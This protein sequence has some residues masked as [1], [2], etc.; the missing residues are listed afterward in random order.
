MGLRQ[1]GSVIGNYAT[2]SNISASGIWTG[3]E[4]YTLQKKGTWQIPP[5]FSVSASA[6]NVNEG[7]SVTFTLS[8]T[9]VA[10]GVLIPYTLSGANIT[11]LDFGTNSL[12]GNF[13][14]QNGTGTVSI[15]PSLDI[16]TEDNE[17]LQINVVGSTANVTINDT[18][19]NP[20]PQF[21]YVSLLLKGDG[22]NNSQNNTFL[23]SSPNPSTIT[24]N[25]N[26]TQGTFTPYGSNW[27]TF[28]GY[29]AYGYQNLPANTGY[30]VTGTDFT[31]EFWAN[32]S[33]WN[34]MGSSGMVVLGNF[35][36]TNGW[37]VSWNG[38]V[39]GNLSFSTYN[40]GA[41]VA[42]IVSTGITAGTNFQL[43]T[44]NHFTVMQKTNVIYFY[45]NGVMTYST[46]APAAVG[47]GQA[48][49]VGV[50]SQNFSYAGNPYFY[51]SNLRIIKGTGIYSTAGFT[52]PTTPLTPIAGTTLLIGQS[53][54]LVDK[55]TINATIT[56]TESG[57]FPSIQR[58]SPFNTGG[59]YSAGGIDG[60]SAYFDGTG[61]YLSIPA[62]SA[63]TFG[64][65]DHTIEFWYYL[66]S[67]SLASGYSTQWIYSSG[68]TQQATNDYFFQIGTATGSNVGLLLGGGGAWAV[69]IQPS[70]SVNAFVGVWTHI[71]WTR[72][73]NTFRLFFNGVQ[74]GTATY[75]GSIT[76]Q[77]G[78]M[79]ISRD[80][81][82][83]Y[84]GGYYS[85]F[86]INNGTSIYNGNFT[87]PT[88]PLTAIGSTSAASY[89]STANVNITFPQ[90]NTSLLCNFTNAGIIDN[91]MMLNLETQTNAK[92]STTQSKFGGSSMSFDGSSALS[93]PYNSLLNFG[94]GNFTIEFWTYVTATPSA[95]QYF[96][97]TGPAGGGGAHRGFR[98]AAHN[99]S[100]AGI[101]F[102]AGGIASNAETLLGSFPSINAWHHIA[103]V[104]NGTTITGY[105]DGTAL[106]T[107]INASTTAINNIVSGEYSFVGA[108]QDTAPA[109]RLF[110][111]GYID[112]LR[113]TN[114]YARYTTNFTPTT[115]SF[116]N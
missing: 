70:V 96:L 80:G 1:R 41:G 36:S 40:A 15:S 91:A 14:I 98:M 109:G 53:S 79:Y 63:F 60:G 82:S 73:G 78:P 62:N 95:E 114:G 45:L 48:M 92:I 68:A 90:A 33:T 61:D 39:G 26:S 110:Y 20:D 2:A 66:P 3:K 13:V 105:V 71:A 16:S 21:Q 49:Y 72:S 107:T 116:P 85:D 37:Y 5:T 24:R 57:T 10:N 22:T 56:N 104:R 4:A 89:S 55:S 30:D 67:I 74:V 112:D 86:R 75:S 111:N 17:V 7:S 32:F 50:Y 65:N 101:Y 25:G 100:A 44:W 76:A 31:I 35:I 103:I 42:S 12:S 108:L 84:S 28:I 46:A 27:S 8:T 99:G 94:A 83:N 34:T 18:S 29:G 106:G 6:A 58:F 115:N 23:D 43:G 87:P 97:S 69:S 64:T 51:Y 113:I 54:T 81:S 52:P 19:R 11:I 77:S 47:A 102:Y 93:I 9:G 88:A 59:G 38:G